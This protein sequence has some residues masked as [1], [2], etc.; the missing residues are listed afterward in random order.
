LLCTTGIEFCIHLPIVQAP[1]RIYYAY[2]INRLH[3][4]IVSPP[5]YI[6]PSELALLK[7][8]LPPEVYNNQVLPLLQQ[9]SLN[10]G[11][12]NYFKPKTTFRFTVGKTL[13]RSGLARIR[14]RRIGII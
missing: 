13:Y 11:R 2:T 6:N 10:P 8:T 12:L 5:D 9:F 14:F 4:G 7:S 3:S 1:C